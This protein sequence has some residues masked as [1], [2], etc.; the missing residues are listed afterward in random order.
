[1]TGASP[2]SDKHA[3]VRMSSMKQNLAKS[4]ATAQFM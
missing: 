1:M 2:F 4:A 3:N